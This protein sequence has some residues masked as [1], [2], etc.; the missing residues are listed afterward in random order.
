LHDARIGARDWQ[1]KGSADILR[2]D[3]YPASLRDALMAEAAKK[4]VEEKV[5]ED[6]L[7]QD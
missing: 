3:A 1:R 6:Y 2:R 7:D 4:E 5:G